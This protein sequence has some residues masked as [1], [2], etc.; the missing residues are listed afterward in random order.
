MYIDFIRINKMKW[1]GLDIFFFFFEM[2][3]FKF[4]FERI[5][6]NNTNII[7]N[8]DDLLDSNF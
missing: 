2:L 4:L 7:I 5:L 6:F 3:Y 1:D 8:N